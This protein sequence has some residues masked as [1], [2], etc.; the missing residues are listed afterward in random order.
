MF[1]NPFDTRS[2]WKPRK[3]L[4]YSPIGTCDSVPDAFR[5]HTAKRAVERF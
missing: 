3:A 5:N 4:P 2:R 1:R